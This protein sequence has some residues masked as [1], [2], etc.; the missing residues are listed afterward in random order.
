MCYL[1]LR[2]FA[3]IIRYQELPAEITEAV[4]TL[5]ECSRKYA[6]RKRFVIIRGKDKQ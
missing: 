5:K 1:S 3:I 6:N 2:F 4:Q